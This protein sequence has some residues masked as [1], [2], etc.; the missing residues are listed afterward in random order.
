MGSQHLFRRYCLFA[1]GLILNAFGAALIIKAS[2]GTSPIS[3]VP[4]SLSLILP[5]FLMV[6]SAVFTVRP[7]PS[8]SPFPSSSQT[9]LPHS[10]DISIPELPLT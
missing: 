9:N 5:F 7:P 6:T 3:A 1:L 10:P 2:M 8:T 4:Y